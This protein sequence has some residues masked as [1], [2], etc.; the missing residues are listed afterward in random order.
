[1]RPGALPHMV[2][3]TGK[4]A[5][6]NETPSHDAYRIPL[7]L[8]LMRLSPR[9]GIN[10]QKLI[11]FVNLCA[12]LPSWCPGW[13]SASTVVAERWFW[14]SRH[15]TAIIC[16]LSRSQ[17]LLRGFVFKYVNCLECF[18]LKFALNKAIVFFRNY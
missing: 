7:L 15:S 16:S 6:I 1:M 12:A 18:S 3:L 13:A 14:W 10:P 4:R 8:R 9:D 5:T 11:N 17:N 2:L